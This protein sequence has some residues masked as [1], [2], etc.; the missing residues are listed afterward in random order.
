MWSAETPS[1]LQAVHNGQLRPGKR[2]SLSHATSGHMVPPKGPMSTPTDKAVN[3]C[4]AAQGH[5]AKLGLQGQWD[6]G[7]RAHQNSKGQRVITY[8]GTSCTRGS[9]EPR[10]PRGTLSKK[11]EDSISAKWQERMDS[12]SHS[13]NLSRVLGLE[14]PRLR[15]G[16]VPPKEL[17]L[18]GA[19][20][21]LLLLGLYSTHLLLLR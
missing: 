16:G 15:R 5:T 6:T 1:S 10:Q 13:T 17:R 9:R 7:Q 21:P 19:F 14:P 11:Q 18:F 4:Q 3:A 20:R 8:P 2:A 12:S